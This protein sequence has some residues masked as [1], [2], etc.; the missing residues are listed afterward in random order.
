DASSVGLLTLVFW[1]LTC[2]KSCLE[3]L[4]RRSP[5]RRF[6]AAARTGLEPAPESRS[7]WACHHLLRSFTIRRSVHFEPLSVPLQHTLLLRVDRDGRL[8]GS[9]ERV[10]LRIDVFELGIAVRVARALAGL[11]VRLQ[12]EAQAAQQPPDQLLAGG[13]AALGQRAG[14]M[15]LALADPQQRRLRIATDRRLHQLGERLQQPRFGLG[16]RL[17]PATCSPDAIGGRV[18]SIQIGRAHV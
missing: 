14:K 13:K 7:R 4:I 5:P 16:F 2:S 1:T 10:D 3:L 9:L 15:A 6:T 18:L 11:L 8:S 12:A 17:A